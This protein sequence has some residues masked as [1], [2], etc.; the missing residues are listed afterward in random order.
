[1]KPSR[2][3]LRNRAALICARAALEAAVPSAVALAFFRLR[4]NP[5]AAASEVEEFVR[6]LDSGAVDG[7]LRRAAPPQ[8]GSASARR[9][10][11]VEPFSHE[12]WKRRHG[13]DD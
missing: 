11:D 6:L 1:M 13:I 12:Q 8:Q 3:R 10:E 2:S 9:Y 5:G 4:L 7:A